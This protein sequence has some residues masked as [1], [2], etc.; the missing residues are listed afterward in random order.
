[1]VLRSECPCSCHWRSDHPSNFVLEYPKESLFCYCLFAKR[2]LT[3]SYSCRG[4][5]SHYRCTSIISTIATITITN[6]QQTSIWG[7]LHHRIT[8]SHLFNNLAFVAM[9]ISSSTSPLSLIK[10]VVPCYN[11]M[12]QTIIAG[13]WQLSDSDAAVSL[14]Q[15]TRYRTLLYNSHYHFYPWSL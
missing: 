1:M 12:G 7:L 13:V 15:V 2:Q 10:T 6:I 3:A 9:D 14:I 8:F 4:G 5:L 11:I